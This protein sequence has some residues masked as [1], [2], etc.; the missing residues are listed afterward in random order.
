VLHLLLNLTLVIMEESEKSNNTPPVYRDLTG[1]R[2]EIVKKKQKGTRYFGFSSERD[3]FI[4]NLSMLLASGVGIL[5]ALNALKV[6][7]RTKRMMKAIAMIENDIEG[8]SY[9]WKALDRVNLIPEHL[10]S[11]IRIGEEAGKLAVNLKVVS[12]QQR[13]EREFKSKI[14]AAMLYPVVGL[15]VTV[16]VGLGLAWFILP[17]LASVF[18]N[19]NIDLP[20]ITR[21]MI[22][23]GKFLGKYGFIAVPSFIVLLGLIIYGIFF[24]P[25]TKFI[26]QAILQKIPGVNKLIYELE[27]ARMGYVLGILLDAGLPVVRALDVLT[28]IS[29]FSNYKKLYVHLRDSVEEGLSFRQSFESYGKID[30]LVPVSIQ[31]LIV[32]A[33]QSG[34]LSKTLIKIG[35]IFEART[36]NTT[37]NLSTILEPIL[38]VIVWAGVLVVALSII[39][40]IYTLVSRFNET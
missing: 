16:V 13:K 2:D 31:Q 3:S 8:G 24:F 35:E 37:K 23:T 33:E 1:K 6:E 28:H 40:P 4:E 17:N 38:L 5:T 11:L 32:S 9:L 25:K 12:E 18:N 34:R 22:G 21:I 39:L 10:I 27:L 29:L 36:D 14:Q 15:S 19:L 26:G 20:L 7:V 30:K